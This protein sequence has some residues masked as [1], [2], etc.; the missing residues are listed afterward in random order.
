M[1]TITIEKGKRYRLRNG[2]ET[3]E[4]TES[5]NGTNYKFEAEVKEPQHN[6]PSVYSWLGNGRYL[7]RHQESKFDIMS[8]IEEETK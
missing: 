8:E 5:N 2:L 4:M 7:N 6:T 3:A 1:E